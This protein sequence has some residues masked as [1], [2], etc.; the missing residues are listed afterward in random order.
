MSVT[1]YFSLLPVGHTKMASCSQISCP[2][3]KT[4][5]ART[6]LISLLNHEVTSQGRAL[7]FLF[8]CFTIYYTFNHQRWD[9]QLL[10]HLL[11]LFHGSIVSFYLFMSYSLD[12]LMFSSW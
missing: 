3:F 9:Y 10:P 6:D 2:W 11:L 5:S 7:G 1:I 4:V 8:L 12:L